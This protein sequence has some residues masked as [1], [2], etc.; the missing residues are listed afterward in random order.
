MST[1]EAYRF[2]SEAYNKFC[3]FVCL[4]DWQPWW[5]NHITHYIVW[6]IELTESFKILIF[7]VSN[8]IW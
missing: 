6:Y 5:Q 4:M 7:E 3:L 2:G 8:K 1:A